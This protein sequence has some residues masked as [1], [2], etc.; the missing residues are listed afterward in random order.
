MRKLN[1]NVSCKGQC[2]WSSMMEACISGSV[3]IN[4]LTLSLGWVWHDTTSEHTKKVH[5][6]LHSVHSEA[7]VL[8]YPWAE[9]WFKGTA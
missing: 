6:P 3:N 5:M 9:V 7:C 8:N 4:N 2:E 1:K